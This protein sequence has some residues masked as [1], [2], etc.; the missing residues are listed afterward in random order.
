MTPG[1]PRPRIVCHMT[2]SVDGRQ[3][4][5]RW[6]DPAEGVDGDRLDSYYDEV[7]ARGD[8]T[9][10][11]IHPRRRTV[12]RY[13]LIALAVIA[14]VVRPTT[15]ASAGRQPKEGTMTQTITVTVGTKTFA[16]TLAQ[17]PAA[18]AFKK[19]LPLSA[20]MTELNGNEKYLRLPVTLPTQ[21]SQPASI[22]A[23]DVMLYGSNTLVIFYQGFS[24]TYSYTRLGRIDDA[25]GLAAALGSRDVDV[26]FAAR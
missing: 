2:M 4:P 5:E 20:S 9:G 7:A 3:L 13:A 21:S 18:D 24:S 16:A 14:A 10:P 11:A 22:Q 6:S 25:T 12:A 23:G 8:L 17:N 19:L 15:T 26:T 1:R